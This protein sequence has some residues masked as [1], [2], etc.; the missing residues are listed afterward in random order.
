MNMTTRRSMM[1]AAIGTLVALPAAVRAATEPP[2]G[3]GTMKGPEH[4]ASQE[5]WENTHKC[6]E[7]LASIIERI[8]GN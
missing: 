1:K 6:L 4:Q 3:S 2:T 8:G 5:R 7:E